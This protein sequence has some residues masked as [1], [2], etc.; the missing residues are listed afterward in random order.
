MK[1]ILKH[2]LALSV[3]PEVIFADDSKQ[4]LGEWFQDKLDDPEWVRENRA[5]IDEGF[6]FH[7]TEK[8]FLFA[9]DDLKSAGEAVNKT[10]GEGVKK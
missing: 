9:F 7:V 8:P 1:H 4:A 3:W 2:I 5:F 6:H 10:D